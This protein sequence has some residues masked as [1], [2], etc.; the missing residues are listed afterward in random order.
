MRKRR[1]I[2]DGRVYTVEIEDGEEK[3]LKRIKVFDEEEG[4][5]EVLSLDEASIVNLGSEIFLTSR[6][7]TTRAAVA[8]GAPGTIEVS[9]KGIRYE[10]KDAEAV[11]D[12]E[13]E[14]EEA[15]P[16]VAAPMPGKVVK[17]LVGPGGKVAKGEALL[18]VESMKME[19]KICASVEG[20]VK[21]VKVS[22]G[23]NVNQGDILVEIEP[24]ERD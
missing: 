18:I 2:V 14:E 1:Y 12:E 4:G 7:G 17:I 20:T 8:P 16:D 19:T 21:E 10:L 6:E 23:Q 13:V 3:G 11:Q 24:V 22:P 15:G 9:L 5:K